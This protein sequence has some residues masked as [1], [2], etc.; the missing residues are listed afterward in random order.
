MLNAR[1]FRLIGAILVL[2]AV[3]LASTASA[4]DKAY[5]IKIRTS[6]GSTVYAKIQGTQMF[7]ATSA[8]G[9]KKAVAVSGKETKGR[10]H[11]I[12]FPDVDLPYPDGRL[13]RGVSKL[14]A[15]VKV[16]LKPSVTAYVWLGACYEHKTKDGDAETMTEWKF[17]TCQRGKLGRSSSSASTYKVPKL[18]KLKLKLATVPMKGRVGVILTLWSSMVEIKGVVKDGEAVPVMVSIKDSAGKEVFSGKGGVDS[19]GMG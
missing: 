19:F 2:A 12:L 17:W 1:G 13:P 4:A 18:G 6:T 16:Y 14:T 10:Y 9:L 15:T 11:Y 7:L 8:A 3:T 5:Y